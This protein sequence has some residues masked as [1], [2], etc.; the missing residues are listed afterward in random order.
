MT[1]MI[2]YNESVF[3]LLLLIVDDDNGNN[4]FLFMDFWSVRQ[5]LEQENDDVL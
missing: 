4:N 1:D 2:R 3:R 5:K